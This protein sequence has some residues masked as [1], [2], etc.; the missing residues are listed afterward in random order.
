MKKLAIVVTTLVFGFGAV[1]AHGMMDGDMDNHKM[2]NGK[3]GNNQ[4][5]D[6]NMKSSYKT[7]I[8]GW[9]DKNKISQGKKLFAKNCVVCHGKNAQGGV[10]PAL[11]GFG[12]VAHHAPSKLLAQINNGGG[13]MP[14]FKNKLT[15]KQQENIFIYLHSIWPKKVKEHYDKKFNIKG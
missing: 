14:P 15:K 2:M 7:A 9:S 4:M 1:N 8:K 5:M 13:G 10:G 6:S 12:H 11:N 3:M